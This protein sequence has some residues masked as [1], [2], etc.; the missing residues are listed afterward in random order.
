MKITIDL[1]DNLIQQAN[2]TALEADTTL[3]G[4]IETALREALAKRQDGKPRR[5]IKVIT[6]GSSGLLPV[7]NL[8]NSSE[9]LDI[10]EPPNEIR[11]KLNG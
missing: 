4:F 6:Y 8:D 2:K 3:T 1:P 11:K 7:V 5:E 9:L 10:M